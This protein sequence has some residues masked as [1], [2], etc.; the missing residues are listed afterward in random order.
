MKQHRVISLVGSGVK[1]ATFK[2]TDIS[3][4][5]PNLY[6]I[7]TLIIRDVFLT[8]INH[9]HSDIVSIFDREKVSVF[10]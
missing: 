3:S 8:N 9:L 6:Q 5:K 2:R 7:A 4:R 1:R 10:W